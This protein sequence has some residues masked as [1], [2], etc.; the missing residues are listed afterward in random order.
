MNRVY[1]YA[2]KLVSDVPRVNLPKYNSFQD[3]LIRIT[4]DI[5]QVDPL[6]I[7]KRNRT[8]K[9]KRARWIIWEIMMSVEKYTL[10]QAGSMFGEKYDHTSVIHGLNTLVKDLEE[11]EYLQ[12]IYD[13]IIKTL[14]IDQK[15]INDFRFERAFRAKDKRIRN[16]KIKPF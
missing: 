5:L 13:H 16:P 8:E 6:E 11:S 2:V 3:G 10:N 12:L 4:C 1:E 14:Q 15:K 9:V 7:Y